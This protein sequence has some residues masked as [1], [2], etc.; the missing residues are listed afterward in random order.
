M[1]LEP[2][3]FGKQVFNLT[4][5]IS[6]QVFPVELDLGNP[7]FMEKL[8]RLRL[9]ADR[10][11]EVKAKRGILPKIARVGLMAKAG[12]QFAGIYFM[13]VRP[14]QPPA[15]VRLEPVW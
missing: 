2:A 11:E 15:K 5:E 13:R 12:L 9:T 10:I 4:T 1:G 3:E 14:N 7:K 8:E 6:K